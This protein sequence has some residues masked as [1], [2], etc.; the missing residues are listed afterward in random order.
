[1]FNRRLLKEIEGEKILI[2]L[3]CLLKLGILGL[4]V[5]LIFF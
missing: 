5:T 4:N 2:F 3:L 1:M